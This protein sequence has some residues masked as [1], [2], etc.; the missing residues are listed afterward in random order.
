MQNSESGIP[1][2]TEVLVPVYGVDLPE[3]RSVPRPPAVEPPAPVLQAP[4]AWPG[5]PAPAGEVVG[6]AVD[7]SAGET[8]AAASPE[9]ASE[10]VADTPH[11]TAAG[12]G[13]IADTTAIETLQAGPET[14]LLPAI[15]A[16]AAAPA[17]VDAATLARIEHDLSKAV[18]DRLLG[19]LDEV[20]ESRIR[21]QLADVLQTAVDGLACDLRAGLK[22]ALGES[23]SLAV[24]AEIK[25]MQFSKIER[26]P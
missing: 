12:A 22:Q 16:P 21:D 17:G 15:E 11:D 8:V 4:Y 18:L 5:M 2:L 25:N 13:A 14:A 19:N 23:V 24:A 1:L 10:A 6:E 7:T 9:P 3:R 20:L 26:T